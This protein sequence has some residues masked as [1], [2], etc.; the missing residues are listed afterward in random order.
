MDLDTEINTL[1]SYYII[2]SNV[3][4]SDFKIILVETFTLIVDGF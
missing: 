3:I 1:L 2:V 4:R